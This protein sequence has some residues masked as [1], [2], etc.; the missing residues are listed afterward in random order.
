[1]TNQS[2]T[3]ISLSLS[4]SLAVGKPV[5]PARTE[6]VDLPP[7]GRLLFMTC[8]APPGQTRIDS[9]M[10]DRQVNADFRDNQFPHHP[11][12]IKIQDVIIL[13]VTWRDRIRVEGVGAL[14]TALQETPVVSLGLFLLRLQSSIGSGPDPVLQD[15]HRLALRAL[16][17]DITDEGIK[18][19]AQTRHHDEQR[20]D[21]GE[22]P[23]FH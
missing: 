12:A 9:T 2:P 16:I 17:D 11:I 4:K 19:K 7:M 8:P 13:D 14:G 21:E 1:M 15:F 22:N 5:C 20:P 10:E 3:F 18:K 23:T 6:C